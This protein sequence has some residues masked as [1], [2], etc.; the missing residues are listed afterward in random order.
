MN[1]RIEARDLEIAGRLEK[2]SIFLEGGELVCLIGP[3]GSGKTTLLHALAGIGRGAGQVSIDGSDP[4][5][6]S[7]AQRI[8]LL[9]YLPASRDIAWPLVARDVIALGTPRDGDPPS[10][11]AIVEELDLAHVL[12]RRVDWLSTGERSRVLIGRALASQPKLLLLD[13][14]I[15]NLDPLWQLKLMDYLRW[16]T[17]RTG[18][19]VVAAVHD[20]EIARLYADRLIIMSKGRIAADGDPEAL[21]SGPN[22]PAVFGIERSGAGWRPTHIK[23]EDPRSSR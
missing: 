1:A 6:V 3:N 19:C 8:R 2:T 4:G 15:S 10:T 14:P 17:R 11:A 23:R 20:L 7:P 12:D 21:L 5:N 22:I 9:A 18:Q 16:L 13:E